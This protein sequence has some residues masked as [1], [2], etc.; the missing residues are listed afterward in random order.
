[1]SAVRGIVGTSKL[2]L[3]TGIARLMAVAL[4]LS[5]FTTVTRVGGPLSLVWVDLGPSHVDMWRRYIRRGRC[6][7]PYRCMSS[8]HQYKQFWEEGATCVA[9]LPTERAEW[10]DGSGRISIV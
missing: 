7:E 3:A 6:L 2:L 10:G 4:L 8:L 5:P 1:M 9:R